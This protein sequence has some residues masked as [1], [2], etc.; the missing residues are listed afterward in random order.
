[1]EWRVTFRRDTLIR[2]EHVEGGRVVEW[3]DRGNEN[4]VEYRQESAHRSLRLHIIRVDH[5][6]AFDPSIWHIDR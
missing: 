3:V 2:L 1:M 5:V 4:A 6:A